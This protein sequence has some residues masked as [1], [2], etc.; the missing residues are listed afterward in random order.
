MERSISNSPDEKKRVKLK[1]L[2]DSRR[3][4]KMVSAYVIWNLNLN[5]SGTRRPKV[6]KYARRVSDCFLYA[7]EAFSVNLELP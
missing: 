6:S 7:L 1:H 4:I 2:A 5:L 3:H